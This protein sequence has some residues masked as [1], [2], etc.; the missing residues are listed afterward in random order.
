MDT[1]PNNY[2]Q[3]LKRLSYH[4]HVQNELPKFIEELEQFLFSS[5]ESSS[6]LVLVLQ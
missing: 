5:S 3:K 4:K 2:V 6:L 1:N